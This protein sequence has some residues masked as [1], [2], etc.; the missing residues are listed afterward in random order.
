MGMNL[1]PALLL[2]LTTL[3]L[4][5]RTGERIA[6]DGP[7]REE[8]GVVTFRAQGTLYSLP[9]SEIDR[10]DDALPTPNPMPPNPT[11]KLRVSEENRKRLLA[12]LEKNHSGTP[13]PSH[14][15]VEPLSPPPTAAQ[16]QGSDED[17][18]QWRREALAY[19]ESIRRAKEE[20][21]L[22]ETRARDLQL[23]IYQL[24]ALGYKPRSFTYDS[25]QLARTLDQIPRA[26]LEVARAERAYAEF[27]EEARRRGVMPGWL[28]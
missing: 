5:L 2:S 8:N 3:T 20:L 1:L 14:Q 21:E 27:R 28:R 19:E 6:I 12:E 23:K 15:R 22:L 13:T 26:K 24:V 17:E 16:Q 18:W 4:V 7:A 11:L 9:A 10:I 25:S